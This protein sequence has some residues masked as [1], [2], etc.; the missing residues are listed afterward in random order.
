MAFDVSVRTNLA[1]FERGLNDLA[2]RQL[3]YAT[4]LAL[5]SIQDGS[6]R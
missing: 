4:A 3:P 2:K 1:D 5:T 6:S